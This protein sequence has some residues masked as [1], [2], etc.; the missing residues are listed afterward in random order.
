MKSMTRHYLINTLVNWRESIRK[1]DIHKVY[2]AMK[3]I[4]GM[5]MTEAFKMIHL[6]YDMGYK[7]YQYKHP[8]LRELLGEW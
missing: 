4:H 2:N 7:W 5:T 6:Y 3:D 8:K 1:N